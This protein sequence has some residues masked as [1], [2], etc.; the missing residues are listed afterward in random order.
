M[1]FLC[2][3]VDF[4]VSYKKQWFFNSFE[5]PTSRRAPNFKARAQLQG[6]RPRRDAPTASAHFI[7]EI[8]EMLTVEAYR[9]DI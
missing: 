7:N 9:K 4:R 2:Q 6:A 5:Q 3:N 8:L 1:M